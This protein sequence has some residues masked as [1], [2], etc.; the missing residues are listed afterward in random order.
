MSDVSSGGWG[1]RNSHLHTHSQALALSGCC[2]RPALINFLRFFL[3]LKTHYIT[4]ITYV[5][6]C[7]FHHQK[8]YIHIIH[9]K[10]IYIS[11]LSAFILFTQKKK[12]FTTHYLKFYFGFPKFFKIRR[13]HKRSNNNICS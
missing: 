6:V 10:N 2:T 5:I 8:I 4:M 12:A 7:V 9:Q 11:I 13:Y 1:P 3:N